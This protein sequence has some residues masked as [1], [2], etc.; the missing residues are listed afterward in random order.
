MSL[1]DQPSVFLVE[2]LFFDCIID[3]A[4]PFGKRGRIPLVATIHPNLAK[5]PVAPATTAAT[6]VGKEELTSVIF[7]THHHFP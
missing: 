7:F 3:S 2:V 4:F 1:K 5:Q 6:K